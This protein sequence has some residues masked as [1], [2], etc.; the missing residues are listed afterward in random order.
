MDG[1]RCA[2]LYKQP[3]LQKVEVGLCRFRFS[4]T[5]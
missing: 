4:Q 5:P 3:V 1:S 2:Q